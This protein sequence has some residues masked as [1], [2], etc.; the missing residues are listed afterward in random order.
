MA[1]GTIR[2]KNVITIMY[3]TLKKKECSTVSETVHEKKIKIEAK[4]LF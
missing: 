1:A 3:V 2:K 4:K